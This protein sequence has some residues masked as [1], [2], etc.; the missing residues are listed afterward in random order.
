MVGLS[1]GNVGRAQGNGG[2]CMKGLFSYVLPKVVKTVGGVVVGLFVFGVFKSVYER[3]FPI[4]QD[5]LSAFSSVSDIAMTP[6]ITESAL[7][8]YRWLAI[9]NFVMPLGETI[10]ALGLF[11]PTIVTVYVV[12]FVFRILDVWINGVL[13][14]VKGG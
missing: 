5:S 7:L 6:G 1:F 11:V 3:Y 13:S 9:F 2:W 12:K 8:S 14:V 4:L 10:N